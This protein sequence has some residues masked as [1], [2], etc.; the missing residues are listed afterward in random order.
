MMKHGKTR[1]NGILRRE[2]Y[3]MAL[4]SQRADDLQI[5]GKTINVIQTGNKG[6][7]SKYRCMEGQ[8]D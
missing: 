4:G 6:L 1:E 5:S 2:R 3:M 8:K 7:Q